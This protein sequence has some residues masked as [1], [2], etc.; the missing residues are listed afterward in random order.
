[1][2]KKPKYVVNRNEEDAIWVR[3][4][5]EIDDAVETEVDFSYEKI[6]NELAALT[7]TSQLKEIKLYQLVTV[8]GMILIDKNERLFRRRL[9]HH[10]NYLME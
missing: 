6:E 5:S 8:R 2:S 10:S 7:N 1:M 9:W 4:Y 3:H